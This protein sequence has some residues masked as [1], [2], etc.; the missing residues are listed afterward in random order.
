MRLLRPLIAVACIGIQLS[1]QPFMVA[2]RRRERVAPLHLAISGVL[3]S[4]YIM[5][6]PSFEATVHCASR[7]LLTPLEYH[8]APSSKRTLEMA[9]GRTDRVLSRIIHGNSSLAHTAKL[10]AKPMP[11]IPLIGAYALTLSSLMAL[12]LPGAELLTV[13]GCG[14]FAFGLPGMESQPELFSVALLAVLGLIVTRS[15]NAPSRLS[16]PRRG[17]RRRRAQP[18]ATTDER[19]CGGQACGEQGER[20]CCGPPSE[21]A[22]PH[23]LRE[24]LEKKAL[25]K[26]HV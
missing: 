20:A 15:A 9:Y 6:T 22:M 18:K 24:A 13:G 5:S 21:D 3:Q 23:R 12:I 4:P 26:K 19:T 10:A 25:E 17:A 11:N 1:Q 14:C 2:P 7:L 16:E 8:R